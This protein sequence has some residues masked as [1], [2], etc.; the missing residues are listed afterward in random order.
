MALEAVEVNA[1]PDSGITDHVDV[2]THV[3]FLTKE[4]SKIKYRR[5]EVDLGLRGN[6]EDHK[7][8][9]KQRLLG[10]PPPNPWDFTLSCRPSLLM[11]FGKLRATRIALSNWSG[12]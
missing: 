7:G 3:W 9:E 8:T 1:T 12:R 5:S 4:Q 2:T 6:T 10:A 11:N